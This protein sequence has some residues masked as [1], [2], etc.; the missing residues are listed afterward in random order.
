MGIQRINYQ[1]L[2]PPVGPYTHAVI[3]DNIIYA[4]GITAFGHKEEKGSIAEQAKA[5]FR[6][7]NIICKKQN[8]SLDKLIKVTV[9]VI[10]MDDMNA[11]REA[12]FD[13]Y[14]E[15]IPASSLVK[16][17]ELFSP[18]LKIEVEAIISL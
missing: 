11:L 3:N 18:S 6:Q 10:N 15:N 5:I 13:I 17:D 16:V 9:F 1:E 2:G 7:L 14:G 12:L 4:S 8:T